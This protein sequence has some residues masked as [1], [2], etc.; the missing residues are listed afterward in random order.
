M[1]EGC[2]GFVCWEE[3]VWIDICWRG[4][5]LFGRGGDVMGVVCDEVFWGCIGVGWV[6]L[7]CLCCWVVVI[8][9]VCVWVVVVVGIW[10]VFSFLFIWGKGIIL[11]RYKKKYY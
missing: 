10:E 6:I 1:I 5:I 4:D 7:N 11:N 8:V 9:A 3:G 2:I